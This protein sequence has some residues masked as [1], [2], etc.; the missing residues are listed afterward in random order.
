[1][2]RIQDGIAIKGY[3]I[4]ICPFRLPSIR[5]MNTHQGI[6]LKILFSI[7]LQEKELELVL[8]EAWRLASLCHWDRANRH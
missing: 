7:E 2:S 3:E 6:T 1:M 4:G 8:D 5:T